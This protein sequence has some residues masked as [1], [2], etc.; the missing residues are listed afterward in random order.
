MVDAQQRAASLRAQEILKI[1]I[2]LFHHRWR[3]TL[4]WEIMEVNEGTV[5]L[6]AGQE[7]LKV[8]YKDPN[9]LPKINKLDITGTMKA[10][11]KYLRSCHGD[12]RAPLA[13]I[14]WKTITVQNNGDYNLYATPDNKMIARMLHLSLEKNKLLLE[15][16][17]QTV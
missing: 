8:E 4:D 11:K 10:I 1:A 13:Y 14:I 6:R 17:A 5:C 9:M 7:K 12:I 16:D 2:F 3:C 15:M